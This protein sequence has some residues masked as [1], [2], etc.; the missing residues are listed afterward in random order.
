MLETSIKLTDAGFITIKI[1]NPEI[2][3][4]ERSGAKLAPNA[5]KQSYARILISDTGMGLAEGELN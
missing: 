4:V 3:I 1:D 2:D 5:T